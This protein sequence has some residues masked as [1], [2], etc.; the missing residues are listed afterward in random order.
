[1]KRQICDGV[2]VPKC[3]CPRLS[4]GYRLSTQ[5]HP[6]HQRA[7]LS[8]ETLRPGWEL[9]FTLPLQPLLSI[10]SCL[11]DRHLCFRVLQTFGL[12]DCTDMAD[13]RFLKPS[14]FVVDGGTGFPPPLPP[15]PGQRRIQKRKKLLIQNLLVVLVCLALAGLLVE[16]FFIYRLHHTNQTQVSIPAQPKTE[17]LQGERIK[18]QPSKESRPPTIPNPS[19]PLAHLT[20]AKKPEKEGIVEWN[21]NENGESF[22]YQFKYKDGKLIVR[23][24]G[25]Y[26]V[27]S[28][29]SYSADST[30]FSYTVER[31]TT[32][33][34]GFGELGPYF[35][36]YFKKQLMRHIQ[37]APQNLSEIFLEK[38]KKTPTQLGTTQELNFIS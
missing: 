22:V 18:E 21:G 34:L 8:D 27:Y 25:Y 9:S 11:E 38:Q 10:L 3:L 32:R 26:Y 6:Q 15:K 5:I 16:G 24:E 23:K 36:T 17:A 12:Q 14:V 19:K 33:Y 20:V 7:P 28:K 31:D 13:G 29:L 1:M 4:P 30:S 37:N 35:N 2:K